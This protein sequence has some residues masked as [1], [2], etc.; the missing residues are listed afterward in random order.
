KT[1]RTI[2]RTPSKWSIRQNVEQPPPERPVAP[3]AAPSTFNF[4][5]PPSGEYHFAHKDCSTQQNLDST[6]KAASTS[7]PLTSS[8]LLGLIATA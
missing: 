1:S 4:K 3:L 5:A 8:G 7:F 2:I 6:F